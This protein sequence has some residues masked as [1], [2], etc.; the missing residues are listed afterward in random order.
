[1]R[2]CDQ[3][4]GLF[5]SE[6]AHPAA[7]LAKVLPL[8]GSPLD[9]S[10]GNDGSTCNVRRSQWK[11]LP[12]T[13]RKRK[14]VGMKPA[15][16][17]LLFLCLA[18]CVG[19]PP[20]PAAEPS[21]ADIA[22]MLAELATLAKEAK[23][24]QAGRHTTALAAFRAASANNAAAY[25]FFTECYKKINFE[26]QERKDS[27]YREWKSD[28]GKEL[29]STEHCTA[30]RYQLQWIVLAIR[31]AN[32]EDLGE[33]IPTILAYMDSVSENEESMGVYFRILRTPVTQSV[34]AGVY[35]LDTGLASLKSFEFTP[36]NF[37]GIFEKTILPYYRAVEEVEPLI[38]A[39]DKR[40]FFDAKRTAEVKLE[41]VK[42][43]Y[44]AE[45]LPAMKWRKWSDVLAM[46]DKARALPEMMAILKANIRHDKAGEWI[47]DLETTLKMGVVS[48]EDA[49]Q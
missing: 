31:A 40:I 39:W 20:S 33:L 25:E 21:N 46:G 11:R 45:R 34:F 14:V 19:A 6:E 27:A 43:D 2:A 32:S 3:A 35:G 15:R 7:L 42:D 44:L 23:E 1:M 24:S 36:A 4:L 8:L 17:S 48:D 16:R 22:K 49:P 47:A 13:A 28:K 38:A 41:K 12:P 18:L 10:R 5:V 9:D 29:R 30:L 37:D 26:D